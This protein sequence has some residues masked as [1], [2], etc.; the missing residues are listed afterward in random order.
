MATPSRTKTPVPKRQAE[1]AE[2]AA[3]ETPAQGRKSPKEATPSKTK[4]P[5]KKRK[6]EEAEGVAADAPADELKWSH[7]KHRKILLRMQK[8]AEEAGDA[9]IRTFCLCAGPYVFRMWFSR[10]EC[11]SGRGRAKSKEGRV[12]EGQSITEG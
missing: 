7:R 8:Q 3:A 9:R 11:K 5:A 1:E 10:A 4:T 12:E 6:A 2:G